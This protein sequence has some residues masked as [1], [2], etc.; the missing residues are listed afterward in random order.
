MSDVIQVSRS[1]IETALDKGCLWVRMGNGN[2]WKARR[3]GQTK[4]WKTRPMDFQIP[5]KAGFR[6]T[7]RI[8]ETDAET[9]FPDNFLI[10]SID[11]NGARR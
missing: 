11:P 2:W 1:D 10:A 7:G 3:N 4:T 5:I 9:G 8:S 6:A